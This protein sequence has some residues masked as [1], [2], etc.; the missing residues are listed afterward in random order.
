[1]FRS[2]SHPCL[3]IQYDLSIPRASKIRG[4]NLHYLKFENLNKISSFYV[5]F[6]DHAFL[7]AGNLELFSN[8]LPPAPERWYGNGKS[9]QEKTFNFWEILPILA[10]LF[11]KSHFIKSSKDTRGK[12]LWLIHGASLNNWQR[13]SV[14]FGMCSKGQENAYSDII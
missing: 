8:S 5:T 11:V 3:P 10:K 12:L 6:S 14:E 9:F 7:G 4:E 13:T 1:M 2:P